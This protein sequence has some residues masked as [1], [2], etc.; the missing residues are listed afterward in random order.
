MIHEH[1]PSG[2][3][4]EGVICQLCCSDPR[5]HLPA[6][7]WG[8]YSIT[9]ENEKVKGGRLFLLEYLFDFSYNSGNFVFIDGNIAHG[10]TTLSNSEVKRFS[11]IM[12]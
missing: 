12:F 11:V 6:A 3:W 10:V 5:S 1:I 9:C 2:G 7:I 8:H 4:I